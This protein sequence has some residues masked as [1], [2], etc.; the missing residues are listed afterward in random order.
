MLRLSK[1]KTD[2][3][4]INKIRMYIRLLA[5]HGIQLREP[6]IKHLDGPIWELR[7]LRY[8][9]LFSIT[10]ENCI[11]LLNFFVKKT[12][13]TPKY[14]IEKAKRFLKDYLNRRDK[15]E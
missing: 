13:K 8:R 5:N 12:K 1:N 6:Y 11:V 7:P 3:I 15:N 2:I 14:E 9:I 10:E 4:K